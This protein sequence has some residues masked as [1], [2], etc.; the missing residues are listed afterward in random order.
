LYQPVLLLS[1]IIR[2]ILLHSYFKRVGTLYNKLL[3]L[4]HLIIPL[5]ALYLYLKV[6]L[7]K[8]ARIQQA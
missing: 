1:H 8:L 3:L 7:L 6:I 2:L 4:H 5:I